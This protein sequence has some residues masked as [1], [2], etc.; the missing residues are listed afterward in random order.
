MYNSQTQL[1]YKWILG[2]CQEILESP[3][4]KKFY[5]SENCVKFDEYI[6]L[7]IQENRKRVHKKNRIY[8]PKYAC[9]ATYITGLGVGSYDIY[10]ELPIG[11]HLNPE[12]R[13]VNMFGK[14]RTAIQLLKGY[15]GDS[16]TYKRFFN[17]YCKLF[18][19]VRDSANL[20]NMYV[21]KRSDY[22]D[23]VKGNKVHI[24]MVLTGDCVIIK[25]ND[26]VIL[27]ASK[28]EIYDTLRDMNVGVS[29]AIIFALNI[30][31]SFTINNLKSN[32]K[33]KS[34]DFTPLYK[35]NSAINK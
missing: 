22:P 14:N 8:N 20:S 32:F 17:R 29:L 31:D 34:F 25:L 24:N 1:Q 2:G 23:D 9:G 5:Y 26:K 33:I 30:E 4:I 19:Y 21:H 16:K 13:L 12:I 18:T 11:K 6:E 3:N 7:C 15:T 28:E 10:V 27:A 35:M